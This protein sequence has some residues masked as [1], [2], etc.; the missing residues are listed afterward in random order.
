MQSEVRQLETSLEPTSATVLA[1][2]GRVRTLERCLTY[3]FASY[4]MLQLY[5][6]LFSVF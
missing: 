6:G 5:I 1:K 3:L 2:L 4:T